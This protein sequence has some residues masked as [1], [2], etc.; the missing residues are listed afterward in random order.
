MLLASAKRRLF[1]A[2]QWLL[3]VA[4]VWF[5]L[6][7]LRGQWSAA[8]LR[9]Q[10]LE[11]QWSW[12]IAAT[13]I[14][15]AT[16]LLLIETWRRTVTGSGQKLTF[17]EA[18]RIWFVSNLGKY[19]PGKIWSIAA[20]TM[21][22]RD[23]S[24]SGSVAAGSSVMVQL[25]TILAG[26]GVVLVT[27]A[28]AVA[29]PAIAVVAA[30]VILVTLGLAPRF[31]PVAGRIAASLTGKTFDF[32]RMR[33]SL[34]WMAIVNSIIAWIAYGIAFQLFV[35]GIIGSSAGATSSYI[36]V[37]A[38][39]YIIGFLAL[40]APGGAVV[41][42]SAIVTGMV[43]FA[44]SGQADALAIAVTSRL[45][46]TVTELVPGLTYMAIGKRTRKLN[47]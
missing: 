7:A 22:A 2:A 31:L 5:A 20:M 13:V 25:V 44:L 3:A 41:R 12:I 14:V 24:V 33:P 18:S 30:A 37:Y 6:R 39:S 29:H 4:I 38:A 16:Y 19:V 8:T 15:L 9:L 35:R 43:R 28:Q 23:S 27:G 11:P 42:E 26:I 40:F 47:D 46:L 1:V 45:W 32:P 21:M 36:A 34:V 10:S 17:P